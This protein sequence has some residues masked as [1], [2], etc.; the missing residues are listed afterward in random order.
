MPKKPSLTNPTAQIA[1]SQTRAT[2]LAS[3]IAVIA[4]VASMFS[5]YESHEAR[6]S[7]VR[8]QVLIRS[9]RPMG[10]QLISIQKSVGEFHYG[11][12]TAPWELLIS[13]TG[14]STISI[15]KYE[16]FQVTSEGGQIMY[17]GLNRGLSMPKSNQQIDLPL[18]LEAGKSI[19]LLA[20]IGI[21]PGKSAYRAITEAMPDRIA[22]KPLS[23]I[24]KVLAKKGI[25]IYDNP[26]I[27]FIDGGE[28][29]GWQVEHLGKEQVFLFKLQTARGADV[30][31]L[32]SWY[33]LKRF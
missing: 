14:N 23:Q 27:P 33:D 10:D 7:T 26:V 12:I 2:W 21:S 29:S 11:S 24:E 9:R 19:R 6:V 31:E 30:N 25:D 1:Q 32:S 20:H 15:T 3:V 28:V 13:N 8:D 17:T 16:V 18:V 4:L 22:T 5:L